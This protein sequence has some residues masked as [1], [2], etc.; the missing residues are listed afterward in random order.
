MKL[1]K[2]KKEI[3]ILLF[4]AI[5]TIIHAQSNKIEYSEPKKYEIADINVEGL[6]H[7][8]SSAVLKLINIKIGN[9]ILIP[10]PEISSTMEKLWKQGLFEDIQIQ[11]SKIEDEKIYLTI[12]LEERARVNNI[13]FSG[14]KES[15]ETDILEL[16][17]I[18][19]GVQITES[20]L[21]TSKNLIKNYFIEKGFF[22]A[23]IVI[24]ENENTKEKYLSD[25]AID[26]TKNQKVKI[27]EITLNG[28]SELKERKIYKQLKETKRKRWYNILKRSK[29]IPKLYQE[30]KKNIVEKY[31]KKG[32]RDAKIVS[33][34]LILVNEKLVSLIINVNEGKKYYFRNIS[35]IG[36][37]I[38]TDDFL[39]KIFGISKGDIYNETLLEDK[40]YGLEGISSLYLDNG[41]LFFNAEPVE[42]NIDND[43]ID[44][45]IRI[46]EGRQA[47]IN[48][49]IVNGNTKTNDHVIYRELKTKPGDLFS[50]ADII[51]TQR[52]LAT[53][54][55]FN[56]ETMG[57]DPK[58][59]P[60][61]GTVDL[62]YNLEEQSSDQIELSVGYSQ[63][64]IGSIKLILTNFSLRN[65][66]NKEAWRPIPSGD[67]Q[68]LSLSATYNPIY[69]QSYN[70]SFV[71]PWLG[72]K[73]PNALSVS[74]YYSV[75]TNGKIKSEAPNA[76]GDWKTIGVSVGLGRRLKKPDD[77][78]TLNNEITYHKYILDNYALPGQ[79]TVT[80]FGSY[81]S[82]SLGIVLSRNSISQPLYPRSG[83]M[84]SLRLDVTPPHSLF[85]SKQKNQEI[86][87]YMEKI[88]EIANF[89]NQELVLHYDST[90]ASVYETA[91]S[92]MKTVYNSQ[93]R[94]KL[95]NEIN[96]KSLRWIEYFKISF[97]TKQY[98]EI[99]NK[100]VL[101]TRIQMG[102]L[103]HYNKDFRSPFERY[104]MGGDGLSGNY[105]YGVETIPM[106]GYDGNSLTP[107]DGGY[108][109][110]KYGAE[111]RYPVSLA[112][113]ATIYV[114]AF[115]EAGNVWNKFS[116][117]SPFKLKRSAGVGLRVFLPMM[118]LLGV[119]VGYGFDAD[120]T[121]TKGQWLPS[122]V[123][124]QQF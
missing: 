119:D 32:Y 73:K 71:E 91:S 43:S 63:Y 46:F 99:V 123:L 25:I 26:I 79:S 116:E 54:G 114:L 98:T 108:I 19:K 69:Y 33:D 9:T 85:R 59:N 60:E 17:P 76:Y 18:K 86:L 15:E 80:K 11:A 62:I 83:S 113:S 68:R 57:I 13:V 92:E 16:L 20:N 118:G 101:E 48:K 39:N 64:L 1:R 14:I 117:Y 61:N 40:I 4:I 90:L 55:Y 42:T 21:Q 50:R 115:A 89:S 109:Y 3:F 97:Q 102:Y 30:D 49:V 105:Y 2:I 72:G 12:I 53:L 104:D 5:S 111:L 29:Y 75:R 31:K 81:N 36:N 77:F 58:P 110:N 6:K 51:R 122:F 87:D 41:Y 7:I 67:G 56:P 93:A 74:T 34:S 103:G 52:E 107:A 65:F 96:E 28:V 94:E 95:T 82:V 66:F 44:I 121:G 112:A 24:T 23:T 78:F 70:L 35:W 10:G 124:G 38:Y 27:E 106:R 45:E 120:N 84:F 88:E 100:L 8:Q 22:N 37:S 47:T